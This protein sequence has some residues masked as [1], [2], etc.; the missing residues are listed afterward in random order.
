MVVFYAA[1]GC[2]KRYV[3]VIGHY[4]PSFAAKRV[5][6][7]MPMWLLFLAPQMID[8][9]WSVLIILGI[10]KN[11]V[12]PGING[13]NFLDNYYIPFTHSLPGALFISGIAFF[14]YKMVRKS[15]REALIFGLVVFSH[16][17]FDL[18]SHRPDIPLWGGTYKVGFGLSYY[19]I[20]DFLTQ[21][22]FFLI[23]IALY[24]TSTVPVSKIGKYGIAVFALLMVAFQAV[25]TM[26]TSPSSPQKIGISMLIVYFSTTAIVFWID[27]NRKWKDPV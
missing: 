20:A 7:R 2:K 21:A 6:K 8:V 5:E 13:E 23:G 15:N 14:I 4:L 22:S 10:E 12:I 18:I 19:P 3:M 26:P 1:V 11:R 17:L 27:K 9:V 16:W 25:L 24:V